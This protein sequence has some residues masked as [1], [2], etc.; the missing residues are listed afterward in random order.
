MVERSSHEED[1][2]TGIYTVL[3]TVQEYAWGVKGRGSLV[4]R[5]SG[6]E[7]DEAKHY[8][9]V[10]NR[11]AASPLRAPPLQHPSAALL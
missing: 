1:S 5:L 2:T 9:E 6:G 4:A 10:S 7:I 11:R 3:P 8:A